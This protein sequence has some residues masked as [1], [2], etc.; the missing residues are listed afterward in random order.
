MAA[1]FSRAHTDAIIAQIPPD[2][3]ADVKHVILFTLDEQGGKIAAVV[4]RGEMGSWTWDLQASGHY[5][6]SGD[7]GGAL[8]MVFMK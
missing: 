2:V 4:K 1:I 5:D 8:K 7:A 6:W 3:P